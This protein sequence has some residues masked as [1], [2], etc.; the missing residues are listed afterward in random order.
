[1][2]VSVVVAMTTLVLTG[3]LPGTK[4]LSGFSNPT[5]W[6]I[7]TAFLFARSVTATGF[8]MRIAWLFIRRFGF[9]SLT[10][11]YSVAASDVALAPFIP[12]DTR[13]AAESFIRH[14]QPRAGI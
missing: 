2:G 5:V 3:T 8:G 14:A 1:M 11:G 7:F 10:L 6:L 13:A 12:S 9:N 4:V